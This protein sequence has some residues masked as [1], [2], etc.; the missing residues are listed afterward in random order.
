VSSKPEPLFLDTK[1]QAP[2]CRA[3]AQ[4]RVLNELKGNAC[5]KHLSIFA[6]EGDK[7]QPI[8]APASA[9]KSIRA[10]RPDERELKQFIGKTLKCMDGET[11][12][13]EQIQGSMVYDPRFVINGKHLIVMLDAYKQLFNDTSITQELIDEFDKIEK[14]KV[15]KIQTPGPVATKEIKDVQSEVN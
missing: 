6:V 3:K 4:W 8:I 5:T 2:L 7:L 9:I 1:C 13:V 15:E 10:K 11:V 12:V 14:I